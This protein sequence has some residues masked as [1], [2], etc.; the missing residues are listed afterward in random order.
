MEA[1]TFSGDSKVLYVALWPLLG[2]L[3]SLKLHDACPGLIT[4]LLVD[5]R[6]LVQ[7]ALTGTSF[8]FD[9]SL[10]MLLGTGWFLEGLEEAACGAKGP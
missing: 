4:A 7:T 3:L 2:A 10:D 1:M 5:V 8:F 6:R 9:N